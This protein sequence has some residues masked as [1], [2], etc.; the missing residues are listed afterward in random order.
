VQPGKWR[1]HAQ[2]HEKLAG[3]ISS[4]QPTYVTAWLTAGNFI[5]IPPFELCE[6]ER[7]FIDG[8]VRDGDN[9]SRRWTLAASG[10]LHLL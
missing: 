4:P 8:K 1:D 5:P 9:P 2:S 6:P 3:E 7:S 10:L